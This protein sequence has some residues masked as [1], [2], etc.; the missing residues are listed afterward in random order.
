[1]R[2]AT[3]IVLLC[4][5]LA[6]ADRELDP[7]RWR[8]RAG[9][10]QTV[11]GGS[12]G[13]SIVTVFPLALELGVRLWGPLSL[14]GGA[15]GVFVGESYM[16]CGKSVRPDAAIGTLGM[17][18]DFLNS[19]ASSWV[20]PFVEAH[21]GIGGQRGGRESEGVCRSPG[22]FGTG[23]AR[24]G[25]DVWLGRAAVT[26]AASWDFLPAAA[27]LGIGLGATFILY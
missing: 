15:T 2:S 25:F 7:P 3:A 1:V 5:S 23:G 6:R 20:A 9:L 10:T 13:G 19:K 16:A 18:V 11:A 4:A 27:P 12:D 24:V 8:V 21:G 14:T 17:R 22:T 26:I